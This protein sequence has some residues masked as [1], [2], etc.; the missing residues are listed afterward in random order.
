VASVKMGD[1][2]EVVGLGQY[3]ISETSHTAEVAFS[4]SGTN[5]REKESERNW[6]SY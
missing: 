5:I 3:S 1:R 6:L 2:E 4:W